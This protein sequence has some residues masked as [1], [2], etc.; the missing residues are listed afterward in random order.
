MARPWAE[1]IPF[2]DYDGCL[3]QDLFGRRR[4]DEVVV[5]DAVNG[6]C[7]GVGSRVVHQCCEL[8]DDGAVRGDLTWIH[9]FGEGLR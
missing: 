8:V 3:L 5:L 2:L 1:F 4:T 6:A 9:R 7:I